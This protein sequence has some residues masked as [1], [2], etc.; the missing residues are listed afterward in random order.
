MYKTLET[1]NISPN[2]FLLIK[3]KEK[4]TRDIFQFESGHFF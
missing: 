1:F 4:K 3:K 2:N